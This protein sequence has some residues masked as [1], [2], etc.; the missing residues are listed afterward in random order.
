LITIL[1]EGDYHCGNLLGLTPPDHWGEY[2][3]M[4][5]PMWD[6]RESELE[7]IGPVDIHVMNGDLT[8][9]PGKKDT[10]G[11][12][13]TNLDV[14][15]DWA[16]ECAGRVRVKPGGSRYLTYGSD[17]HVVNG[18]NVERQVARYFNAPIQDTLLLRIKSIRFNFR[19]FVGRSDTERGAFNQDAREITRE[20]IKETVDG[21][22]AADI[23]GRSHVH[24][25]SRV[26]IKDRTAYT[27]PAWELPLDIPGSTY[28][29]RLRTQYYDVGYTIIQIDLSGEVY[30][31][32]RRMRIAKVYPQEYLCPLQ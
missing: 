12:M 2:A 19:H 5:R 21:T 4:L 18:L 27:C 32:P 23:Y 13:T 7:A 16:I 22:E 9:G 10:I 30:I 6:F 1:H 28:P 29:R 20:L 8:D 3:D 15:A 11:L 14:Q 25:W 26:D 17:F 24:Y 31:R